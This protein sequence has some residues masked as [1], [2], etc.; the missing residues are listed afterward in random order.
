MVYKVAIKDNTKSP[1]KYLP[2]LDTFKN[3][4]EYTFKPGVNIIVGENGCGKTTL[5][6]LIKKYLLVDFTECNRGSYGCNTDSLYNNIFEKNKLLDGVEVYADYHK[7]TFRLSHAGEKN[8]QQALETFEDFGTMFTQKHSST[9]ESV[10]VAINSLFNYMFSKK[11]KLTFDYNQFKESD[12]LYLEYINK[13]RIEG[14]EW[15]IL[16]DEPDRNLDIENIN[17]IKSILSYHKEYTQIIAVVH[18]PLLIYT[19]SK[20]KDIN[21]IEMTEGYIHKIQSIIR[22]LVK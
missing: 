12:P 5:M 11:A 3:D 19:L 7:N 16:M 2:D 13:H 20:N 6:N 18:N 21:F 4:I 8:G 14:D 9:G 22:T 10:L 17:Q 15:T 1:I